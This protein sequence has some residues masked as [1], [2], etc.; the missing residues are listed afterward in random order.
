MWMKRYCI[1][2]LT[3]TIAGLWGGYLGFKV[4]D[5]QFWAV[6]LPAAI[7][8]NWLFNGRVK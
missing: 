7:G 8:L 5:W 1:A 3:G 2:W 6:A 4:H